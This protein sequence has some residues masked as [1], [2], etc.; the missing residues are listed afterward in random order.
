MFLC[1]VKNPAV[2]LGLNVLSV[3]FNNVLKEF[4]H[5]LYLLSFHI[6]FN[7]FTVDLILEPLAEETLTVL[8]KVFHVTKKCDH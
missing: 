7:V 2:R 6:K 3:L 1:Q 8:H 4:V 5:I